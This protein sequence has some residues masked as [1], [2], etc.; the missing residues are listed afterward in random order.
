M[1][2]FRLN[3]ALDR[4]ALSARFAAHGRV[5]V[6]GF[7][8]GDG[9]ER[10]QR[11]LAAREDWK[12]L[13][14]GEEKVFELDRATREG[15]TAERRGALD[16]AV[17]AAAQDG[18]QFRYESVRVP[19]EPAARAT[20]NDPLG[21]FACWM[22]GEEALDFLRAVTGDRAIAFADAQ[23]TGYAPGDFLTGHDDAVAGKSRRAAYVL[24][25]TPVWRVE[26]GGLLLHHLADGTV[27]GEVPAFNTLDVFR[28]PQ[29]H[30]VSLV[31]DAAGMR[32]LSVTGWL[33][34]RSDR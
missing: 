33:R 5:R 34:E 21:R 25:L 24:G 13:I 19:D 17:Y 10:L 2:G 23:A 14:G 27:A 8:A 32:R 15:F 12:Q 22:A 20:M 31:G 28:V 6:R 3:P 30:S 16:A 11:H 26:W 29:V 18:F 4:T 9:A 7:L 1:S